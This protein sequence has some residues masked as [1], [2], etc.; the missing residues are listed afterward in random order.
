MEGYVVINRKDIHIRDPFIVSVKEEE[1]YYLYGTT[2]KNCWSGKATGFDAYSSSDLEEWEGPITVFRPNEGFWADENFWA[3]EI[4]CYKNKYY[5]FASFKAKEKCRGT[6]ILV[7]DSCRGPF[8]PHS[9]GPVTPENWECLDGTLYVDENEQ[10]WMIFCHEWV[11]VHDG[12]ICAIKLSPNL[13]KA[14]D[15]PIILF[16]ASDAPWSRGFTDNE[17][18]E[19]YVTDGPFIYKAQNGELLMLWS[20]SGHEGY[21]IGIARSETGDILGPWRQ[22]E[23]PLFSKDGGHGMLFKTFENKLMLTIHAPN[24]TPN[25]RPVFFELQECEGKLKLK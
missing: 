22:D 25:E 16:K 13:E 14:I 17:G 4:Y 19:Q 9:D 10:A 3:P 15:K 20:T 8:I 1:K 18:N 23:I 12:E 5:M 7:A 6:Q 24:E 11:Q 2:D 21:T